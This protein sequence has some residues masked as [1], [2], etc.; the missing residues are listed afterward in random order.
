MP[1]RQNRRYDQES[2]HCNV[3]RAELTERLKKVRLGKSSETSPAP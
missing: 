1:R 2:E 3:N